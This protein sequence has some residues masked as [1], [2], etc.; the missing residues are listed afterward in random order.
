MIYLLLMSTQKQGG[1]RRHLDQ[2]QVIDV[3]KISVCTTL[4][5]ITPL[6]QYDVETGEK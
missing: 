5:D 2:L 4:V 3:L 1:I 6:M